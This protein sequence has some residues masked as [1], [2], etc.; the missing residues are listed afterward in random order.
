MW[1]GEKEYKCN[2]SAKNM[3]VGVMIVN[4]RTMVPIRFVA[5]SLGCDVN[6]LDNLNQVIITYDL[7]NRI[8]S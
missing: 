5:E 6:W 1:V 8:K 4:G 2:G 7:T 3:D